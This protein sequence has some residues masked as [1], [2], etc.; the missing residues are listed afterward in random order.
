MA[1][2]ELAQAPSPKLLSPF[3]SNASQA[4]LVYASGQALGFIARMAWLLLLLGLLLAASLV[5]IWLYSFRSGWQF[6]DWVSKSDGK[7]PLAP[8]FLYGLIILFISPLILFSD[9][10]QQVI[11]RWLNVSLPLKVDLRQM[12][13]TQLGTKLGDNFPF[14]RDDT[15]A[16]K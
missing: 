2:I 4:S 14:L 7:A 6:W 11:Q 9:W 15:A 3:Q 16:P 8:N 1:N 5:W 12:V 10:S 13:E